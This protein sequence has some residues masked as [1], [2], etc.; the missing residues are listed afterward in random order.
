MP[1]IRI[2]QIAPDNAPLLDAA[3]ALYR[4]SIEKSEQRPEPVFRALIN[5]PDYRFL[6]ARLDEELVGVAA[7]WAPED[8]DFWLFEYA[9]VAERLRGNNIGANLFVASRLMAGQERIALVEVDAFTGEEIQAK[10]LAFYRR[11]GC[12]RLAG[13]DYILPLDAFGAP[14]PMWLLALAQEDNLASVSVVEVEDWL[15]RIYSEVYLKP[16]DDARLAAMIDPLPD[17]V[18]LIGI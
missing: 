15:R 5:R 6:A 3:F 1:E 18:E 12:R 11:L 13:L 14:P 10:R 8:A 7:S 17:D 16:L 4:D 2:Q 9:A